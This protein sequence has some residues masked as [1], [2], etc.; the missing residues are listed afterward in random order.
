MNRRA[1]LA[2]AATLAVVLAAV[3]LPPQL[4]AVTDRTLLNQVHSQE[5]DS[6]EVRYV[7]KL[8]LE[9]RLDLLTRF[10]EGTED[11]FTVDAPSPAENELQE[12]QAVFLLEEFLSALQ[13][14]QIITPSLSYMPASAKFIRITDRENPSLYLSL[15][16]MKIAMSDN[17]KFASDDA[18]FAQVLLDAETGV[19]YLCHLYSNACIFA[20]T[21]PNDLIDLAGDFNGLILAEIS[22]Y[23]PEAP[24]EWEDANTLVTSIAQQYD[25]I[26]ETA[27]QESLHYSLYWD[28]ASIL[29]SCL[30]MQS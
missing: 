5:V 18:C 15:W 21:D 11:V 2:L 20:Q 26:Y 30:P 16:A 29:L 14:T 9:Q 25:L 4:S 17:P 10:A 19:I 23:V 24:L 12:Q 7:Y 13:D 27:D 28:D 8:T 6:T 3:L 22:Q 1:V